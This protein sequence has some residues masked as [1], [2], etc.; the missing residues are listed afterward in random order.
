MHT[1]K[2]RAGRVEVLLDILVEAL[3]HYVEED[4]RDM[5]RIGLKLVEVVANEAREHLEILAKG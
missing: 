4:P 2:T 1:R 5:P 3:Q